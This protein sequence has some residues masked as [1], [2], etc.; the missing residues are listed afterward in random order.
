MAFIA[1]VAIGLIISS[2][3]RKE[4]MVWLAVTLT[5][6][7]ALVFTSSR[8]AWFAFAFVLYVG[9]YIWNKRIAGYLLLAGVL[10]AVA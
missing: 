5:T 3:N 2:Q 7:A 4:R 1:P 10:G 8:G 9:C 6:L